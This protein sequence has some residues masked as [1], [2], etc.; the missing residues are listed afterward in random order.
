M[1]RVSAHPSEFCLPCTLISEAHRALCTLSTHSQM[2]NT[3]LTVHK[4]N[5]ALNTSQEKETYTC[6]FLSY[7]SRGPTFIPFMLISPRT[8]RRWVR[9]KGR[10]MKHVDNVGELL[11]DCCHS[12]IP[13]VKWEVVSMNDTWARV[14]WAAAFRLFSFM[15]KEWKLRGKNMYEL[16]LD[17]TEVVGPPSKSL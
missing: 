4:N 6:F 16:E 11:M 5:W 2:G 7:D 8:G 1:R 15:Q 3:A 9:G 12:H 13:A 14:Q 10:S 17:L